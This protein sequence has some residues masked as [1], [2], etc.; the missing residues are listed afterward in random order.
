MRVLAIFALAA[1]AAW[2]ANDPRLVDAAKAGRIGNSNR[3]A[4]CSRPNSSSPANGKFKCTLCKFDQ[5]WPWQL[6]IRLNIV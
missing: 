2:C 5:P 1:S 4:A 6:K 3:K